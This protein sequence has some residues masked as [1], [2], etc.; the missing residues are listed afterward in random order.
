[1]G[2]FINFCEV[3]NLTPYPA[4]PK[5]IMSFL[6]WEDILSQSTKPRKYLIAISRFHLK[7]GLPDP[8]IDFN[9]QILARNLMKL[10]AADHEAACHVIHYQW[11][12]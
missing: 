6:V 2:Q 3:H 11:K 7:M 5:S 8:T 10:T 9:V 12:P 4:H 1:M